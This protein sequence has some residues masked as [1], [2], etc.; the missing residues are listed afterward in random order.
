M[1]ADL[2]AMGREFIREPQW[3]EKIVNGDEA[4]I[5]YQISPSELDELA[6]PRA[7][8]DYLKG[9]SIT[10]PLI[11]MSPLIIKMKRHQWKG[12]KRRCRNSITRHDGW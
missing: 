3:V 8:Q 11:R 6:I 5:R 7:M 2:V 10:L 12:L 4:S 9:P 1:G